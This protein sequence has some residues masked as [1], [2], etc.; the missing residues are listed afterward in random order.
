MSQGF[1]ARL[2]APIERF[3]SQGPVTLRLPGGDLT[4]AL[5]AALEFQ[6]DAAHEVVSRVLLM[7]RFDRAEVLKLIRGG[8]VLMTPAELLRFDANTPVTL[9]MDADAS[10]VTLAQ[11]R[12]GAEWD[13]SRIA[14][15]RG[16]SGFASY[17]DLERYTHADLRAMARR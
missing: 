8:V 6:F 16:E 11:E 15:H 9:V 1:D 10:L 5:D 17:F 13:V 14:E 2:D 3:A 7:A 4:Q 12:L